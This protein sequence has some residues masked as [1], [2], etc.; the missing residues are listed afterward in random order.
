MKRVLKKGGTIVILTSIIKDI[1]SRWISF[2]YDFPEN[3]GKSFQQCETL[4]LLIKE[5]NI[6]LHDYNRTDDEYKKAFKEAVLIVEKLHI[7]L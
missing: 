3:Q 1:T 2:D 4:K 5:G 6:I 7:P